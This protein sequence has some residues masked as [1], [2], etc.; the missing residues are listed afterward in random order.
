MLC[1]FWSRLLGNIVSDWKIKYNRGEL[2]WLHVSLHSVTLERVLSCTGCC[3]WC[4]VGCS[5]L[6]SFVGHHSCCKLLLCL[7]KTS[8][9]RAVETVHLGRWKSSEKMVLNLPFLGRL[10]AKSQTQSRAVWWGNLVCSCVWED[11]EMSKQT[12]F[13]PTNPITFDGPAAQFDYRNTCNLLQ[14]QQTC[15]G[16]HG[17]S[18]VFTKMCVVSSTV[19]NNIFKYTNRLQ[20]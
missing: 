12:F 18:G 6:Y 2:W 3:C 20:P 7:L 16:S 11:P 15:W 4:G 13:S 19:W 10:T 1:E 9:S 14:V 8:T 5:S 17:V